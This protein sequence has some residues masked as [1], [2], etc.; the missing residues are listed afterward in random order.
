MCHIVSLEVTLTLEVL[1]GC[2]HVSDTEQS[3]KQNLKAAL[4]CTAL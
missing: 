3:T 2:Q 1:S 4:G